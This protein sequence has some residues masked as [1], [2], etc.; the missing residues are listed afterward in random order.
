MHLG[1]RLEAADVSARF[2][3]IYYNFLI[4]SNLLFIRV[5]TFELVSRRWRIRR[6]SWK[7]RLR[8]RSKR[9]QVI[10]MTRL[11]FVV[12]CP[13]DRVL[14]CFVFVRCSS[15]VKSGPIDLIVIKRYLPTGTV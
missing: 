11:V 2:I 13:S 14:F 7:R 4:I 1:R 8:V 5:A 15:D 10:W 12:L 6:V 3:I 9:R